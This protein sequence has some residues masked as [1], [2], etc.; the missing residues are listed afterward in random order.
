MALGRA[1]SQFTIPYSPL[2]IHL[3]IA[4]GRPFTRDLSLHLLMTID[5]ARKRVVEGI[6]PIYEEEEAKN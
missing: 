3:P 6:M 5:E 1:H 4:F 2:A